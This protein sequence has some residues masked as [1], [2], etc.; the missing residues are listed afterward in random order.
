VGLL[1]LAE[2]GYCSLF[3]AIGLFTRY[4]LIAGLVY[5]VAFEGLLANFESVA[6]RLT[7]MYYFRLLSVRW[8]ELPGNLTWSLDLT[9]APSARTCVL[10]L[11]GASAVLALLGAASMMRSEFRMKTPEGG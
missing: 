2:V 9:L 3:A 4:A 1:A 10:T 6:R 7:V 11:L 5:I 8:L